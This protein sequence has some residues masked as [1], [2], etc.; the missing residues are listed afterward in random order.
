M[1]LTTQEALNYIV[2][3]TLTTGV[4]PQAT[5]K[6][7]ASRIG[8]LA[9]NKYIAQQ[10]TPERPYHAGV[11][12]C[13]GASGGTYAGDITVELRESSGGGTPT[14]TATILGTVTIPNATW[15]A[16]AVDADLFV[17]LPRILSMDGRSYFYVITSST[18]DAVNFSRIVNSGSTNPYPGNR[19]IYSADLT[20][21]NEFTNIDMAF[22]TRWGGLGGA[23]LLSIQQCLDQLNST[24]GATS[25]NGF[26]TW[27]GTTG[28]TSQDA[29]NVKAGTT[30]LRKQDAANVIAGL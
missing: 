15:L 9:A 12:I 18:V 22:K 4:G 20:S 26:N 11:H 2:G 25:R 8:E 7:L 23:G 16:S 27:A 1:A 17:A 21:W 10:F 3:T 13:R 29:I 5:E 19:Y 24:T 14:P 28:R 30:G 6:T